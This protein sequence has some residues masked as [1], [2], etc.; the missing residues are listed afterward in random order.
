M[1]LDVIE[2]KW[3]THNTLSKLGSLSMVVYLLATCFS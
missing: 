2:Q 1:L 3:I